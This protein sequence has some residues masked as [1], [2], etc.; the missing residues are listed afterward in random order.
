MKTT[1]EPDGDHWV[2][3]GTKQFITHGR[4][5]D[6]IVAMA[7]TNRGRGSRGISAFILEKG[8]KGLRAEKIQGKFSLRASATGTIVMEDVEVCGSCGIEGRRTLAESCPVPSLS[9]V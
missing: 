7:V 8:M 6:L 9:C 2:L 4:T 3:N 5:G 1:A